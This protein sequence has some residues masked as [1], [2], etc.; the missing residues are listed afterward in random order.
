MIYVKIGERNIEILKELG[1]HKETRN[2]R[3][4]AERGFNLRV[5]EISNRS[6]LF[7]YSITLTNLHLKPNVNITSNMSTEMKCNVDKNH[8]LITY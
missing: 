7:A 4:N 2:V 5:S 6:Q 3:G 1:M 8:D